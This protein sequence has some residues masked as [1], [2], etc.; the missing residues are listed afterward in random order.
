MDLPDGKHKYQIDHILVTNRFKNSIVN[1]RSLRGADINSDHVL[2]G[3]CIKVK[4]KKDN[5]KR[6]KKIG[7]MI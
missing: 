7:K 3:I 4:Q 5:E 2:L 1:I 6:P